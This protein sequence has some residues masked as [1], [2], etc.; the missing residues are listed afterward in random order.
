M[1][2][3]LAT[4]WKPRGEDKRFERLL[5]QLLQVYQGI[6]VSLPPDADHAVQRF[7]ESLPSVRSRLTKAWPAGRRMALAQALEFPADYIH[8]VDFDRLLRWVE[9]RL[10]EWRAIAAAQRETDCLIAGRTEAAYASHPQA[11]VQTE[12]ISNRVVSSLIGMEVDVS[13]GSKGFSRQAAEFIIEHSQLGPALGTDAEWPLLLH[14]GGFR[15]KYIAVDGLDWESADRHQDSAASP[16]RQR[17][18]A[19]EYDA[20]P[21]NWAARVRIAHEIVQVGLDTYERFHQPQAYAR[22]PGP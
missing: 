12:A 5:P 7:C 16:E 10:D 9:T 20:D 3:A 17:A 13:A 11:L 8:Y 19:A 6:A 1:K 2:I 18:A 4:A 21:R 15:I 22:K 14:L